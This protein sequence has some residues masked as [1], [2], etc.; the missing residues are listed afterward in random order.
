MNRDRVSDLFVSANPGFN[1]VTEIPGAFV[2]FEGQHLASLDSV[3][4]EEL[5]A[6]QGFQITS[7]AR[8]EYSGTVFPSAP[9]APDLFAVRGARVR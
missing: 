9:G 7:L 2:L 6:G 4:M 1:S 5:Q 3:D 8:P